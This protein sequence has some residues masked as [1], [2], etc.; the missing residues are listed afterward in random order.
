MSILDFIFAGGKARGVT[1]TPEF[2]AL[3]AQ[4]RKWVM[5]EARYRVNR[6][7]DYSVWAVILALLV[8]MGIQW[9]SHSYRDG[10]YF[11]SDDAFAMGCV[12][13]LLFRL[14][15]GR[16]KLWGQVQVIMAEGP[17]GF[18][19]AD[20]NSRFGSR[21]LF[22]ASIV[23]IALVVFFNVF[24]RRVVV[25]V[26]NEGDQFVRAYLV[27]SADKQTHFC[28]VFS[29]KSK[30]VDVSSDRGETSCVLVLHVDDRA[31][32]PYMVAGYYEPGY[33]G[34]IHLVLDED[35]RPYVKRSTLVGGPT[36]GEY[37]PFAEDAIL[38]VSIVAP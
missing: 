7:A 18:P 19:S 13:A 5:R 26:Y 1:A 35:G 22:S 30:K 24:D 2:R 10:I 33:S 32:V 11:E 34:R 37:L 17:E 28:G 38:S 31:L 16:R 4:R 6:I 20:S 36:E 12:I 3:T 25:T 8:V 21:A 27:E 9:A 29:R 15:I 23:G 14:W